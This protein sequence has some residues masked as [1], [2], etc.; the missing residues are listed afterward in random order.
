[1]AVAGVEK[2]SLIGCLKG[3]T[4]WLPLGFCKDFL[5]YA[6]FSFASFPADETENL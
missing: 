1:M 4:E 6:L 5:F 2:I 3:N